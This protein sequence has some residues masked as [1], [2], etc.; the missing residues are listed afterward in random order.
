MFL[1]NLSLL[2]LRL[3]MLK[4]D[5]RSTDTAPDVTHEVGISAI[6]RGLQRKKTKGYYI[7]TSGAALIWDEPDGSKPGTKIWDDV[8]DIETITSMP[9]DRNHRSTDKVH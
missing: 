6:L 2:S 1:L 4:S 7:Q 5:W 3:R 9:L 8:N